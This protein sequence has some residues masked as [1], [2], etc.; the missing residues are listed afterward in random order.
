MKLLFKI[1]ISLGLIANTVSFS[2]VLSPYNP[3]LEDWQALQNY[4]SIMPVIPELKEYGPVFK[5][6]KIIGNSP[7]EIPEFGFLAVH[8]SEQNRENCVITYC[9]YNKNYPKG[10]KR[11][12]DCVAHS[13]FQGHLYYRIGGWPDVGHGGLDLLS[14][15]YSFKVAFFKEVQRLG[16][17]RALWM[18]ASIVPVA[19]LNTIFKLIEKKGYYVETNTHHI[20]KY[21]NEE[22]AK[23]FGLSLGKTFTIH[24]CSSA[25]IGIDFTHKKGAQLFDTWYRATENYKTSLSARPDQNL[26][27]L[28]LY[29]LGITDLWPLSP[30]KK[31]RKDSLFILNRDYVKEVQCDS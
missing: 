15:P 2:Q 14:I 31:P 7:E 28:V 13:D 9:S 6:F 21:M 4:L 25:I 19:S 24:S 26:L 27:S 17:K 22:V 1:I 5:D 20:G 3:T 8:S 23:E 30:F 11:L 12:V 10:V 29:Q 18:D 16:Y